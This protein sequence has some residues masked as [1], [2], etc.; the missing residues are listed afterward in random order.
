MAANS[1]SL[2]SDRYAVV[3]FAEASAPKKHSALF[4]FR[5]DQSLD[6]PSFASP[7]SEGR[8]GSKQPETG[9]V[10][11]HGERTS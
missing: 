4:N 3:G 1:R 6:R 2:Q 11:M 5:S 9:S 10:D 8:R 7:R